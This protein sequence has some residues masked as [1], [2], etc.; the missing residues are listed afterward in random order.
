MGGGFELVIR[1]AL[2]HVSYVDDQMFGKRRHA[3]PF[4]FLVHH[5]EPS[6]RSSDQKR[7]QVDVFML[8]CA[9]TGFGLRCDRRIM[10]KSKDAVFPQGRRTQNNLRPIPSEVQWP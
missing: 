4:T 8:P 2:K 6:R 10:N 1:Q 3:G 7:D 5:F 9:D